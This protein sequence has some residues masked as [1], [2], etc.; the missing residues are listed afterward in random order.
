MAMQGDLRDMTVADL[1]QHNCQDHKVARLMVEHDDQQATLFFKD[2]TVQH[3]TMGEF[4]GEEVVYQIV[5]WQNGQFSLEMDQEPP[6]VTI[7]RSWSGLLLEAA[8]RLDESQLT[9]ELSEA[10][11]E[12]NQMAS[13]LNKILK[14]LSEQVDGFIATAVVGMDGLGIAQHSRSKNLDVETINAQMSMFIKLVDTSVAKLGA[15]VIEDNLLTTEKAY[16]L[17]RYLENKSYYLGIAVDCTKA[18]L[19]NLRLISRLYAER[20]AQAMPQ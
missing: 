1:I 2:G 20:V 5:N 9:V 7:H 11:T 19:G 8:R 13:D 12:D 10:H 14:D 6:A 16:L 4:E 3:A 17:I 15:G 18:N